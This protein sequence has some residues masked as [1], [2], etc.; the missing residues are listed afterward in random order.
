MTSE[1][2]GAGRRGVPIVGLLALLWLCGLIAAAM[3]WLGV[4]LKQWSVS[5]GDQPGEFEDL[6]RQASVALLVAA[7]VAGAGPVLIALVA[8]Q[9]RQ[10]RTAVVFLVLAA[11]I[12]VPAVPFAVLAGRDLNPAPAATTPGPPGHC[13]EHSGGDTRCPGG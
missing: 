6:K 5:Y 7:V 3:W 10:V 4:G 2:V 11:V 9:L 1:A 8:Y 12:A 13:V